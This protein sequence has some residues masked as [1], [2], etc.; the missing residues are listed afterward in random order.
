ML[1]CLEATRIGVDAVHVGAHGKLCTVPVVDRTPSRRHAK[2]TEV[3]PFRHLT[4]AVA[5]RD[6][7]MKR[8]NENQHGDGGNANAEQGDSRP[9]PSLMPILHRTLPAA[10]RLRFSFIVTIRVGFGTSMPS[11]PRAMVSMRPL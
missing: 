1:H 6:L 10:V 9:E 3:L 7:Q 8:P 2:L 11:V 4:Q 5:A